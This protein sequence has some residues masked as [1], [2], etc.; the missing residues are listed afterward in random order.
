MKSTSLS[1]LLG[2]AIFSASCATSE[3]KDAPGW[4]GMAS[5][6]RAA[7]A[8]DRNLCENKECAKLRT[9]NDDLMLVR[10]NDESLVIETHSVVG[11]WAKT[12]GPQKLHGFTLHLPPGKHVLLVD[13]SRRGASSK[14][15]RRVEF[16]AETGHLYYLYANEVKA[17]DKHT[18]NPAIKDSISEKPTP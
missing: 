10:L 8:N 1:L 4:T 9:R 6:L 11:G 7:Y 17:D 15:L 3:Y 12:E 2:I 16:V 5:G 13:L 18:W 14:Y